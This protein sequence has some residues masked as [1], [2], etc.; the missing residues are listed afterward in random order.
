[1]LGDF[2]FPSHV[3]DWVRS[4]EGIFPFA[5]DGVTDEKIGFGLM[6][7]MCEE[8]NLEQLVDK[9]TWNNITSKKVI[10]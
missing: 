4:E 2:N 9:K 5:K 10:L 7:D 3:V 1:M 8:F 6:A